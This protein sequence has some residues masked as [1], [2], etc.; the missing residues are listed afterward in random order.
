MAR[1]TGLLR[2]APYYRRLAGTDF[3]MEANTPATPRADC[4]FLLR[5]AEVLLQGRDF[6]V[7][8]AAYKQL[9]AGYWE[10]H[11]TSADVALRLSSAW[12]LLGQNAEHRRA[13]EVIGM[14]GSEADHRKLEFARER[15]AAERRTQGAAR[16]V[17]GKS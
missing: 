14:D 4:F 3:S 9:C 17:R 13:R 12:G 15:Q 8:E 16:A 7:V 1:V 5:G 10:E 2:S 6:V 11:L